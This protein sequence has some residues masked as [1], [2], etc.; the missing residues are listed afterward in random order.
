MKEKARQGER[1]LVL[2]SSQAII[3]RESRHLP[4]RKLARVGY[5]DLVQ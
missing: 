2:A 3:A 4:L 5:I 1:R